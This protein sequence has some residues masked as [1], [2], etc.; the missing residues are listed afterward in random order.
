MIDFTF[1]VLTELKAVA[2]VRCLSINRVRLIDGRMLF[3]QVFRHVAST[4]ADVAQ[5]FGSLPLSVTFHC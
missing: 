2:E 1:R 5:V 3:L 4:A